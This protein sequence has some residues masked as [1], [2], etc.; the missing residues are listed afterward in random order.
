M[1]KLPNDVYYTAR[2]GGMYVRWNGR[3]EGQVYYTHDRAAA[4]GVANDYSS[5]DPQAGMTTDGWAMTPYQGADGSCRRDRIIKMA[6][7]YGA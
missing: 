3:P 1:N 4:Y 6:A 2:N 5:D 7:E